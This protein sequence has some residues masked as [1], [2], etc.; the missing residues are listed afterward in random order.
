[1]EIGVAGNPLLEDYDTYG[2]L[3]MD[4]WFK[5]VWERLAHYGFEVHLDYSTLKAPRVR[6]EPIMVAVMA[7]K[8]LSWEEK[9]GINRCQLAFKMLRKSDGVTADGR[10][11]EPDVMTAHGRPSWL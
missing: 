8:N 3:A 4:C 2:E 9:Q 7:D 11:L 10:R 6:D 1:M 5:R